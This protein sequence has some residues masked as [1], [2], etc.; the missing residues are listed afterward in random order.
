[1][2][3]VIKKYIL[4]TKPGIVFGKLI[5]AAG[6]YFSRRQGTR[7]WGTRH[8]RKKVTLAY[9]KHNILLS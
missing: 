3:Q 2:A 9:Y 6:G 1:M 4:V 7:R 8:I 5:T